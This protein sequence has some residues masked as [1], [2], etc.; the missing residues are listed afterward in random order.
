MLVPIGKTLK[1]Y[2]V[3]IISL[4]EMFVKVNHVDIDARK[5]QV[6]QLDI[7]DYGS[8]IPVNQ[9]DL[10]ISP[11]D[12][13]VSETLKNSSYAAIFTGQDVGHS[14]NNVILAKGITVDELNKE[15]SKV[16]DRIASKK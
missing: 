13:S 16:I 5:V 6:T 8:I 11:D 4:I 2:D 3:D 12:E 14:N 10:D 15:K 9:L 7:D 1:H